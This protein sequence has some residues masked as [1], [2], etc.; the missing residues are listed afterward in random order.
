[1][2]VPR[3][4]Q[5]LCMT[6]TASKDEGLLLKL[7][8]FWVFI[9]L[10]TFQS[11]ICLAEI[12]ISN[13]VSP[14]DPNST[15]EYIEPFLITSTTKRMK[16]SVSE[17]QSLIKSKLKSGELN[18][19]ATFSPAGLPAESFVPEKYSLP[20]EVFEESQKEALQSCTEQKC[21]MKLN[22][23]REVPVI[24]GAKNKSEAYQ[25]L[26]FNRIKNYLLSK[27]MLGYEDRASNQASVRKMLSLIPSVAKNQKIQNY[28]KGDFWKGVKGES[29]L[30]DSWVRQEMVNI[31]PDQMQP[32]LRISED[33]ELQDGDRRGF[34]EIHIYTNH[35]FDSS[36][37]F[38]EVIPDKKQPKAADVV[39]TDVMEIDEL[40]KTALI[41]AMFKGKMVKAVTTYQNQFIDELVRA[42][43][44]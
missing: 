3:P 20:K 7:V 15:D 23:K 37:S 6:S 11:Q 12:S 9:L 5:I 13:S 38:Y 18:V 14:D 36:I 35:Y 28:F 27:E 43:T 2:K 34:L 19:R 29:N 40:K 24:K 44:K 42:N 33:F 39:I 4:E 32:I 31:A 21:L 16:F 30:V 10:Q 41:R 1:M 8:F 25:G 26:I 22:T 17:L